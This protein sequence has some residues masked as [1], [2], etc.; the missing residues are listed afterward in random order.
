MINQ[1]RR[2]ET[3]EIGCFNPS[4]PPFNLFNSFLSSHLLP[5][6]PFIQFLHLPKRS[7]V[8]FTLLFR[9]RFLLVYFFLLFMNFSIQWSFFLTFSI[10]G[11]NMCVFVRCFGGEKVIWN[12]LSFRICPHW[13]LVLHA[14]LFST[15]SLSVSL[16]SGFF[17]FIL[18]YFDG[19]EENR[20]RRKLRLMD[21]GWDEG[22]VSTRAKKDK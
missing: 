8:I 9:N 19:G 2:D 21:R 22:R 3:S 15:S 18:Y 14:F 20:A 11:I 17:S 13:S 1:R 10:D 6:S 5:S 12:P 16:S 4:S 7:P